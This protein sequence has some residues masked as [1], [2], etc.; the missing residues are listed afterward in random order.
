[1]ENAVGYSGT[2]LLKKLGIKSGMSLAWVNAPAEFLENV[3]G[4]LPADVMVAEWSGVGQF[5]FIHYFCAWRADLERDILG[6]MRSIKRDGMIWIS[7]PKK[8]AK[9]PGDI[10][11]NVLREAILPTGLVDVKVC[12]VDETWSGLKFVIRAELR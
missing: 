8:A 11:E 9:L 6:L 4:P 12:A 1:M 10:T 5:D 3:L 2:P 7:W